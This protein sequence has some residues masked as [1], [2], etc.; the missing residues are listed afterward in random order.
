[1]KLNAGVWG[2]VIPTSLVKPEKKSVLTRHDQT[3]LRE[4]I[5]V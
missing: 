4:I 5:N 1:M 2:M 3:L